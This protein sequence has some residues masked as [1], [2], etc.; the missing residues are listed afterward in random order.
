MI[1]YIVGT[2]VN[3]G[4]DWTYNTR[5]HDLNEKSYLVSSR[6]L[7][8]ETIQCAHICITLGKCTCVCVRESV[9]E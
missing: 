3:V 4:N 5:K 6:E 7:L 2:Q 9:C 1:F 8:V